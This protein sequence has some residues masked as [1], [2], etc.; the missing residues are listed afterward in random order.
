MVNTLTAPSIFKGSGS[1]DEE[2]APWAP[3]YPGGCHRPASASA[4]MKG[5]QCFY[6]RVAAACHGNISV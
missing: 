1:D 6:T 3:K 4:G 5:L 2:A